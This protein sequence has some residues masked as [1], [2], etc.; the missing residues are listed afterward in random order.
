MRRGI[1]IVSLA[2]LMVFVQSSL[3]GTFT[4]K[5]MAPDLL[6]ILIML[7][8]LRMGSISAMRVGFLAGF[9]ADC[10][11]PAT[12]GLYAACYTAAGFAG[13]AVR[14]R[15]YR[16]RLSSQAAASAALVLLIVPL[17]VMFRSGGGFFALLVRH[18][19]G[20]AVYTAAL[21]VVLLPLLSRLLFP[22]PAV[23]GR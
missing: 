4:L 1:T 5:G 12:M 2:W 9:L 15:I 18:G 22:E 13:G 6:C 10:Y 19:I 16:E 3:A 17:T 8:A 11:H 7:T 14:D 21:S 23:R 20:S